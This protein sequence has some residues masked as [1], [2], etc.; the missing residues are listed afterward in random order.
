MNKYLGDDQA[1]DVK[2]Y[3]PGQPGHDDIPI[4]IPMTTSIETI[5]PKVNN[6]V[7]S[8]TIPLFIGGGILIFYLMSRVK[9]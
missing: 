9:G 8:Y 2:K 4:L 7:A 3:Y 6:R 1:F 5:L